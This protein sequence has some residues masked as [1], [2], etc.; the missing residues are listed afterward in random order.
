MSTLFY[1]LSNIEFTKIKNCKT[2][3]KWTSEAKDDIT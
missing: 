1:A 2:T 3:Y